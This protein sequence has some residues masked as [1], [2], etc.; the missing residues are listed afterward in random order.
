MPDQPA[1]K[2]TSLST[3]LEK[4]I[5]IASGA[6][7]TG[8]LPDAEGYD[9]ASAPDGATR[10]CASVLRIFLMR[11]IEHVVETR[12]AIVDLREQAKEMSGLLDDIVNAI[13]QAQAAQG[14]PP[15]QGGATTASEKTPEEIEAATRQTQIDELAAK[16][17]A[18]EK[19]DLSGLTAPP[20]SP[21][22]PM[23]KR[24]RNPA[25]NEKV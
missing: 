9:A 14:Q 16:A 23:P 7:R 1:P 21:V 5:A 11:V 22:V 4:V 20:T 10:W 25:G 18:G 19:P 17:A 2:R 6:D 15:P 8:T 24:N 3:L 13:K 12:K